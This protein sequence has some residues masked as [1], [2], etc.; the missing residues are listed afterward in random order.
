MPYKRFFKKKGYQATVDAFLKGK[1]YIK[2]IS[3]APNVQM[4]ELL[5]Q[6]TICK[7][8]LGFSHRI[9]HTNHCMGVP[10]CDPNYTPPKERPDND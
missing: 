10:F 6:F 7:N 1:P 8:N 9:C 5:C 4:A 3:K 2:G